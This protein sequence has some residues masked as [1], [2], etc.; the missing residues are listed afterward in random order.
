[1]ADTNIWIDYGNSQNAIT[2][3]WNWLHH[4]FKLVLHFIFEAMLKSFKTLLW[5]EQNWLIF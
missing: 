5:E 2:C 1:M 3:F 4:V